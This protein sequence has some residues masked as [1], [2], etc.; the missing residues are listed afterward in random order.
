MRKKQWGSVGS[1]LWLCRE[2]RDWQIPAQENVWNPPSIP[3][4]TDG[5]RKELALQLKNTILSEPQP[6]SQFLVFLKTPHPDP[7]AALSLERIRATAHS[8]KMPRA[9][10]AERGYVGLAPNRR[11]NDILGP[12]Q[13]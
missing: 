10:L 13:T 2:K 6:E 11:K 3:E 4:L 5:Q 1:K 7:S 12:L 9:P 8:R